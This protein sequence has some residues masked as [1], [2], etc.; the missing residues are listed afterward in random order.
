MCHLSGPPEAQ[1]LRLR[2][3][4][5]VQGVGF[6]PFVFRLATR[7]G[8][9]GWVQNDLEGVLIEVSGP[10]DALEALVRAI[11]AEAPPAARVEQVE[12][13][14]QQ[15]G[16]LPGG[17]A[18][19]QSEAKGPLSTR[20]SP[21]LTLCPDCLQEL[22]DPS[23]RRYRYPFINCT[24]CGPRY[25]ITLQ[26]PYDRPHTTMRA[27][28]MCPECAA[29]YHDP[30][31]RRFHAQPIACPVC[32][33]QVHLWNAQLQPIASQHPAIEEAARLLRLGQILAIKGLG[34]YH[35]ACDA[36]RAE[37]VERLR[38]RKKRRYKP[39]ALMAR[40]LEAL[41]G[42]VELDE[43][44]QR[45]L[46]SP[47]R[48]IVLLPKGPK[49]LPEA[50]APGSPD[51]GVMLPYTPLQHLLFA[52]GAPPLLVMTSANRSGEPMIY[53]D[54]EIE[55]LLGLADYFLVG[56]RPIARRVDDS[57]A[58][59][60]DGRPMLLRRARSFAPTPILQ[61]E[62]FQR[63]ILALG[64]M[65]KNS[66]A[67]AARGQVIVSQHLGDLEELEARLAFYETIRDLTQM[68]R[69]DLEQ[70]LVVH[71]LHPDYPSTQYAAELPG[72]K[73]AVQHHQAHI[74]AVL[75]EHHLWDQPVLGFAF[76]GAGLGLDGAIW[77][78]EVM[79]GSL[80]TGLRRVAHLRY[81]P[82]LGGDAAAVLPAQAAVGFVR[83]LRH[84][85][86]HLPQHPVEQGLKLLASRLPIPSTSSVGRLF[87]T[88]AALL[89][90]HSRQDFEGQAAMWLEGIARSA[91]PESQA[92]YTLSILPTN[93]P[94]WDYRP[95]LE[96]ILT[97]M[98]KGFAR[99]KIARHF[100]HALA[101]GV[102]SMAQHLRELHGLSAVAL[103]GGVWQN[104]LL[105]GLALHV[106]RARGF[107]VYWNQAVPPGDGGI[108]LGQ[109]ALAQMPE[110]A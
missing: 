12:I 44:A 92:R 110:M 20:I 109:V 53:R 68:Y 66:I 29:E 98:Q 94:Q 25:S 3:R 28:A 19:V 67:L 47:E 50:L 38:A 30:Y 49:P 95:L 69:M 72:P 93:P 37:A 57:V 22:F 46:Q 64:A 54:E 107:E 87:D 16:R 52:E 70:T 77:G 82:L 74:A 5:V 84:W 65:L 35:L 102:A 45:L 90:F 103:S 24:N 10:P 97:D 86:D 83:E 63:P 31:N 18:I 34:G 105:H 23:D 27:F 33:P 2:V 89:G 60:A 13:L 4:G 21:D 80:Q 81:A 85:E 41:W 42:Y 61:S 40:D 56:E 59:L 104:R 76:D 1:T 51:L 106:L 55:K 78:G 39:L 32:G 101:E 100:H 36:T 9:S 91:P 71:D 75:A 108:A 7:L 79:L 11:S 62:R 43:P 15:P 96:A 48:P 26:L 73:R 17:F 6:R 58:A 99:E 88:V 8:L 14:E